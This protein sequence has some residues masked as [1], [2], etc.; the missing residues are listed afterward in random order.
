MSE[1]ATGRRR[2]AFAR[3]RRARLKTIFGDLHDE[4]V[5][6]RRQAIVECRLQHPDGPPARPRPK[7][8]RT[9][10][11]QLDRHAAELAEERRR[12]IELIKCVVLLLDCKLGGKLGPWL[13]FVELCV[14]VC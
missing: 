3:H 12:L 7:K 2:L 1:T 13:R 8:A 4:L 11:E 14:S 10:G 6:H 9:R 5:L